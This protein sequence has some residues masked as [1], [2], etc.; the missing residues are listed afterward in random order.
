MTDPEQLYPLAW[1]NR[2]HEAERD[3]WPAEALKACE[4]IERAYPEWHPL[5]STR[6]GQ[7]SAMRRTFRRSP[8][9][10]AATPDALRQAIE[11][12]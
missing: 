7:Y 12:W 9:V 11:G 1:R 4:E 2:R 5:Y 10:V 8:R 3:G 6:D